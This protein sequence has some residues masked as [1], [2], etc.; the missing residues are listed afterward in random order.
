MRMDYGTAQFSSSVSLPL[1]ARTG[2]SSLRPS[3][4]LISQSLVSR[5]RGGTCFSACSRAGESM[6]V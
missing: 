4:H 1:G 6:G 2:L 5:L 3:S